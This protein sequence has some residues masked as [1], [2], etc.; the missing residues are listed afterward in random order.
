MN[1]G[2]IGSASDEVNDLKAIAVMQLGFGPLR[3]RHDFAIQFDGHAIS[4]HP[5]FLDELSHGGWLAA[6]FRFAIDEYLHGSNVSHR[7]IRFHAPNRS[8]PKFDAP[9]CFLEASEALQIASSSFKINGQEPNLGLKS[10]S[11]CRR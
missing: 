8:V 3:A 6:G 7:R 1:S 5:K 9:N 4:L 2:K 11:F 10:L